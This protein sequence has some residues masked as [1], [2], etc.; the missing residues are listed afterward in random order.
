MTQQPFIS[1]TIAA[2]GAALSDLA[3]VA[4]PTTA[5]DERI[6]EAFRESYIYRRYL[7]D[8]SVKASSRD[9]VLTLAGTVADEHHRTL[10]YSLGLGLDGVVR[11]ENQLSTKS[12]DAAR[13]SDR[14]IAQKISF[15][16]LLHRNVDA[17]AT[18]VDV[19]EGVVTLTGTAASAAQ[20]DLTTEYASD[21]DGVKSVTNSM[22][23]DSAPRPANRTA[24]QQYD[25]ASV[26][27]HVRTA[28][29]L[30][31]SSSSMETKVV[32]RK[33][34]VTITGIAQN[35]AEK[36]LVSKLA[37]DVDGVDS[38]SNEMTVGKS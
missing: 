3:T 8:D 2:A 5:L 38:V 6:E 9:G 11:V 30:H 33:G 24:A 20:R 23:V 14:W 17:G 37:S 25:D 7:K 13:N 31:R 1:R 27:A 28:L 35:A 18:T 21:I 4:T 34:A 19:K 29:Q 22:L 36:A 15:T 12:E 16:L 32:T 26:T 10:A